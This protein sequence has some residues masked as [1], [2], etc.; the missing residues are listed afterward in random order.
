MTPWHP[1]NLSVSATNDFGRQRSRPPLRIA[2]SGDSGGSSS[3]RRSNA[4]ELPRSHCTAKLEYLKICRR[5]EI[6]LSWPRFVRNRR[7]ERRRSR[8]RLEKKARQLHPDVNKE[9]DAEDR[10]H[11]LR[12][13]LKRLASVLITV[14][15]VHLRVLRRSILKILFGGWPGDIF[16]LRRRIGPLNMRRGREGQPTSSRLRKRQPFI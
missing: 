16:Q 9:F 6:S 10:L 12:Y 5:K 15:P 7:R 1:T 4:H 2:W 14:S 8:R 13:L 3:G 11:D